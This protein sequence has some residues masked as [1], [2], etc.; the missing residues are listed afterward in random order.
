MTS[1]CSICGTEYQHEKDAKYCEQAHDTVYV[2]L[3]RD[4][5][6]RLIQ[7]LYTKD[8]NLLTESLVKTLR[9]YATYIKGS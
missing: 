3:R 5:L 6:F 7:F 4:D 2:P 9:K 8:E 1:K